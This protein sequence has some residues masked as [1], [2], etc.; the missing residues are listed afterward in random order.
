MEDH[1]EGPRPIAFMSRTLSSAER[2]YSAYDCELAAMAF[3]FVKWRRYLE[4]APDESNS[5]QTTKH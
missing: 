4:A 2:K 3:C 1:G 5:S